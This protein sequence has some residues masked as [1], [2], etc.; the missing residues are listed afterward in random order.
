MTCDMDAL[1]RK[2]A[3]F[4]SYHALLQHLVHQLLIAVYMVVCHKTI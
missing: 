2:S 4:F 3:I 1:F